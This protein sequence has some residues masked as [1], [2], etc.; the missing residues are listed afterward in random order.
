M[1][2]T[3]VGN[4]TGLDVDKGMKGSTA[5]DDPEN[6]GI[7]LPDVPMDRRDQAPAYHQEH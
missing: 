6:P 5:S 4:A 7:E 2:A 3:E 1:V